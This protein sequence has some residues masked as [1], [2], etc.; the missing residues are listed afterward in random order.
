MAGVCGK[1]EIVHTI[2]AVDKSVSQRIYD[3]EGNANR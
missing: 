1:L 2:R 3:E